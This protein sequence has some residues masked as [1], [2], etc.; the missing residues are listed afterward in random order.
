[1]SQS[2]NDIAKARGFAPKGGKAPHLPSKS[3]VGQGKG[4][5]GDGDGITGEA[6]KPKPK[7][8]NPHNKGGDKVWVLGKDRPMPSSLHGVPFKPW[9]DVPTTLEG[10]AAVPGQAKL[11]EPPLPALPAHK[12]QG[13][14][15]IIREPDGR[16]W[17]TRP[18][19]AFGGYQHTF[20]KGGVEDGLSLQA[21]AIKEAFE[22]TGLKVKITG[23][24]GDVSRT[25]S[26][27]RYY[28]AERLGGSPAA[29]GWESEAMVLA[30][31]AS[32]HKL[33]NVHIDQALA[34]RTIPGVP[35]PPPPP[36]PKPMG[37]FAE[38]GAKGG[39]AKYGVADMFPG[40]ANPSFK[41][42]APDGKGKSFFDMWGGFNGA[43]VKKAAEDEGPVA[44][45][46]AEIV[47]AGFRM[48]KGGKAKT[49]GAK[50]L[51]PKKSKAG[52]GKG[53]DGDKDG[54]FNEADKKK[55]GG[56]QT[57]GGAAPAKATQAEIDAALTAA[58]PVQGV[59]IKPTKSAAAVHGVNTAAWAGKGG[60][61]G[62]LAVKKVKLYEDLHAKGDLVGLQAVQP[63]YDALLPGKGNPYTKGAATAHKALVADLQAAQAAAIVKQAVKVPPAPV[64]WTNVGP[65][66]GSNPGG[67]FLDA[68][69]TKHYVKFAK[70]E[71]HAANEVTATHL[72]DLAGTPAIKAQL[73]DGVTMGGPKASTAS[74]WTDKQPFNIAN[75]AH[76]KAAHEDFVTHAWLGNWDAVGTGMDN[77]ALVGGKMTVLDSG[78]SMLFR[79]Q[80]GPKGSAWGKDVLEWD[81]MRSAATPGDA[82]KVF[83]SMTAEDL[84]A[85]S[86]K[87]AA[88]ADDAI[89][90][91]VKAHGPG[92]AAEKA[93]MAETLI[94]R[95]QD[96]IKRANGLGLGD[97]LD[98]GA[99]IIPNPAAVA[100]VVQPPAI[101]PVAAPKA[102]PAGGK[103][104]LDATE[105]A[106]TAAGI[107]IKPG[108]FAV[109]KSGNN[110]LITPLVLA[111]NGDMA[112]LAAAAKAFGAS[113]PTGQL[114]AELEAK[115]AAKGAAKVDISK[116]GSGKALEPDDID[117]LL[118]EAGSPT[119]YA[120]T[121]KDNSN[122]GPLFAAAEAGDAAGLE[123]MLKVLPQNIQQVSLGK[124]MLAKMTVAA[125]P[126]GITADK[127][128][129]LGAAY[130]LPDASLVG[131]GNIAAMNKLAIDGDLEGLK[132]YSVGNSKSLAGMHKKALI[133]ELEA[134]TGAAAIVAPLDNTSINDVG[135]SLGIGSAA[136]YGPGHPIG[137]MNALAKTGKLGALKAYKV[138]N[139]NTALAQYQ[140][141]LIASLDT[142]LVT[143][144]AAAAA[145]DDL[146]TTAAMASTAVKAPPALPAPL[147][148]SDLS[149]AANPISA[150]LW[151]NHQKVA[152][153]AALYAA[154]KM[155][156]QEAL[157]TIAAV[158]F[159][160]NTYG[161]KAAKH[162]AATMASISQHGGATA[163]AGAG[164]AS[165]AASGAAAAAAAP[166]AAPA[167][168]AAP[169]VKKPP[170]GPK[171]WNAA[172]DGKAITAPPSFMQ[173]GST[174]APGPS[175]VLA[176][177]QANHD[178]TQAIYAAAQKGDIAAIQA[179]K[180]QTVAKGTGLPDG[181]VSVLQHPSQHIKSYANSS[182]G[183]IEYILNPPK[184]V[185]LADAPDIEAVDRAFDL[186]HPKPG[187]NVQMLGRYAVLGQ[188]KG[189]DTLGAG[190]PKLTK[191]NGQ[192]KG[193]LYHK[194][195]QD[196]FASMTAAQQSAVVSYTGGGYGGQNSSLWQGNPSAAAQA[197]TA[198]IITKGHVVEPGT[199]LSRKFTP[200]DALGKMTTPQLMAA[201]H[202]SE[203]KVIQDLG[204][205][206]TSINPSVWSGNIQLKITVGPGVKGLY[207]GPGSKAGGGAISN[208]AGEDE[209]VLPPNTRFV[210]QRVRKPPT[211]KDADGFPDGS[212]TVIEIL[213]LPNDKLA[214]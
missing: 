176:I 190:L 6:D 142:P 18:T 188:V 203:G 209:I 65:Q 169:K 198:A 196:G 132:A 92:S 35:V 149:S 26:N 104:I 10:W 108:Q 57:G 36:P 213:A 121:L 99:N 178:A 79:A 93:L 11:R 157:D 28:Y 131:T 164:K 98:D 199:I 175:T 136:T 4:R 59:A 180:A 105:I 86:K 81:T 179:M 115:L 117:T 163:A 64:G 66:L 16:V 90:A 52:Q 111:T 43:K 174:G 69:G 14:G 33:L 118:G 9:D 207:V 120:D 160:T 116:P 15:V 34:H 70:S 205:I 173:W 168:L 3:R 212:D 119:G 68:A 63:N 159:G 181:E 23:F 51:G 8:T 103:P 106:D 145:A 54:I 17:L 62:N 185:S 186:Y 107:G 2:F 184:Q 170:K 202:N 140:Q 208:H 172:T 109:P 126:V 135:A 101:K 154:G 21:N 113:H 144:A 13:S 7:A 146:A 47:K 150:T 42:K 204:L 53:R 134:P 20:P 143:P 133:A 162:Q 38:L 72:Y 114:A 210:V 95:K 124:T 197:A 112:G 211:S 76:V 49:I 61:A 74:V 31:P 183:E 110:T 102:A 29:H 187:G 158:K 89:R 152:D 192:S 67:Q 46:F 40:E 1:M 191:S 19:N 5:D 206:S 91:V 128:D 171:V 137:A 194:K 82:P 50:K 177:N 94:A 161:K 48:P 167:A 71:V 100:K 151:N 27:A 125:K 166:V 201:F 155:G 127:L 148:Q 139:G 58:Q 182:I 84:F 88:I 12:V 24:A 78:G 153:T 75:P 122:Y 193:S 73:V 30:P 195:A 77:L 97:V 87:V 130:G 55:V 200:S 147:A 123:A 45:T 138:P 60:G 214:P 41:P 96:I 44:H 189:G 156:A 32:L 25:T 22:E 39:S 85:S 56:H 83:G 37:V 129:E 165:V 141:E 80:G